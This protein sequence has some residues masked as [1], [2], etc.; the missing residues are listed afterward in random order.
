MFIPENKKD[1]KKEML[2]GVVRDV[3][4][5]EGANRVRVELLGFTNGIEVKN[6]AWYT[7]KSEVSDSPN[8]SIRIPPV[9]S[10]V[11]VE[12]RDDFLNGVIVGNSAN[13]PPM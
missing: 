7:L 1:G 3:K 2:L 10:M 11:E 8:A 6:L 12:I 5:P 9:G 4:D 13:I